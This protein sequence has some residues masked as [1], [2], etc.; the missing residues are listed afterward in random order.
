MVTLHLE[1]EAA[2]RWH[3]DGR[4][5]RDRGLQHLGVGKESGLGVVVAVD[6][7]G[8]EV[9][10]PSHVHNFYFRIDFDIDGTE[11]CFEEFSYTVRQ[12]DSLQAAASWET[13][14]RELGAF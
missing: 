3:V 5:R 6:P 1:V 11:N 14:P 12:D 10:A 13:V 4:S 2:E 9:F 7:D 8:Q